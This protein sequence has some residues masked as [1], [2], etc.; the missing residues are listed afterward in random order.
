MLH[1]NKRGEP[2]G[3]V[4][5]IQKY[6]IH[7]GPGIRTEIFFTGCPLRCLWCS[8]PE[9]LK[10]YPRLGVYPAKCLS[11]EKCGYCR[12][13]CPLPDA[14]P[15]I[16]DGNGVIRAINM[17]DECSG[18]LKCADACPPRAIKVW[19]DLY[20]VDELLRIIEEDRRFYQKTGG[21]VTLSGGEVMLQW[22]FARMLLKACKDASI[23]TC[24]ETALQCTWAQAEAV[25]EYADLIIAD[26]KHMDSAKHK[27]YTGTGNE[28]IL[29][30]IRLTAALGKP[31]VLRT[32]VVTGYNGD[33]EN[34]RATGAF[35]RDE[36]ISN[37]ANILQYQLLPYRKMGT[38]KYDS[39]GE[40]YPMGDYVPPER[41]EWEKELL[42]LTD[43]L[44]KEY[45]V[46][47]VSGSSQKLI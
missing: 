11:L 24:V 8:N 21:G 13:A 26:I 42:R 5:N 22:E 2:A 1:T 35:I 28:T 40:S 20:S 30:N 33:E 17:E 45:G 46:P 36:L 39:L 44:K 7:D 25:F 14:S 19:G 10:P 41:E 29:E 15:L 32:P 34:I 27:E 4:S 37:G 23:N 47:A 43:I 16:H 18:C 3:L 9:T 6:T 31:V 38:E 12:K